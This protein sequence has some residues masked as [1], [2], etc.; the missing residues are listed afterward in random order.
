MDPV[1]LFHRDR[2]YVDARVADDG[3]VVVE[4]QDLRGE[5]EVEYVITV[6][7]VDVP[8]LARALGTTPDGVLAALAARGEEVV[9]GGEATWL[10]RHGVPRVIQHW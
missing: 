8:A 5:E 4:G 3:S 7:P 10:D 1:V 9:T 6:A 2:L